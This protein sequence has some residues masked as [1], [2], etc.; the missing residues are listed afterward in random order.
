MQRRLELRQQRVSRSELTSVLSPE[1]SDQMA[2]HTLAKV[3][4]SDEPEE[5]GAQAPPPPQATPQHREPS[6]CPH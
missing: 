5:E 1:E 6:L 4:E 3:S 2:K